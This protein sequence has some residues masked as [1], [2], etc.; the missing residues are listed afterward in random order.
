M[1]SPKGNCHILWFM[2]F[3]ML[4]LIAFPTFPGCFTP[5]PS[6][7]TPNHS[8]IAAGEP[9]PKT[10]YEAIEQYG[11]QSLCIECPAGSADV[12]GKTVY[13]G[14]NINAEIRKVGEVY[15]VDFSTPLYLRVAMGVQVP[16]RFEITKD[17]TY[18]T[19]TKWGMTQ[20]QRIVFMD[21][22]E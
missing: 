2:Y 18:A 10:A 15:H 6:K 20:R 8:D 12:G 4:L 1:L 5:N 17:G 14:P 13:W 22:P 9:L 7:S 21:S 3:G 19:G 11:L 16:L